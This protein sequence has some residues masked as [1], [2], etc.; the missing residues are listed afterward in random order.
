MIEAHRYSLPFSDQIPSFDPPK[1]TAQRGLLMRLITPKRLKENE[2]F[3]VQSAERQIDKFHA[4]GACEFIGDYAGR[5]TPSLVIADLLGVPEVD[6]DA[7]LEH[8]TLAIR[9]SP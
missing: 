1:H 3:L 2:A 7:F 4:R 6:H 5:L 9:G 8:L